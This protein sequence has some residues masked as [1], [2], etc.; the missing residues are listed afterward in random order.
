MVTSNMI[1]EALAHNYARMVRAKR[2]YEA[3]DN[4][5]AQQ[6]WLKVLLALQVKRTK[7]VN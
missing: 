4:E 6:Y 2:A 1:L 3:S 7:L 5:W